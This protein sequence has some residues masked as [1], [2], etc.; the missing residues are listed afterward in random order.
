MMGLRGTKHQH[1][2]SKQAIGAGSHVHGLNSQ[3]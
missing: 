3:P 2:V 1:D